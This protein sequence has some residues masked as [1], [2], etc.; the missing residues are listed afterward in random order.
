MPVSA[1]CGAA[2]E[3]TSYVDEFSGKGSHQ[4]L[5]GMGRITLR[6][7]SRTPPTSRL[8]GPGPAGGWRTGAQPPAG[9]PL[10]KRWHGLRLERIDPHQLRRI[11]RKVPAA[12]RFGAI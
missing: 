10:E 12:D 11:D 6:S 9:G 8:N 5:K 2:A 1:I 3:E 7:P 4:I